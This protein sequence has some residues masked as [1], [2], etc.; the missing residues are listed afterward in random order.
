MTSRT[1][2]TRL[3]TF[4][5]PLAVLLGAI[6]CWFVFS[7][8][9]P[10]GPGLDP[11][12]VQYVSAAKSF[13]TH[14]TFQ[15]PDDSWDSPDSV[16]P[17]THFP[18]GLSTVLAAPV[19]LG[20]D[21]LQAARVVNGVAAL[22]TIGMVFLFVSWA[23]GRAAGT[24][25]AI[26]VAVTPAV[27]YVFLDVLSEPLFFAL[28][29]VTLACMVWRPRSPLW[30]GLGAAAAAMVRYAGVSVI[31]A[32]GVWSL[33]LPGTLRERVRRAMVALVPGAIALGAWMVRT[34]LETNGGGI[35]EFKV[36]G[37]IVPTL[38]EGVR[39]L[40]G[41]SAPLVGG[42]WRIAPA[43]VAACAVLVLA[44]D[45]M[46]RW[47]VRERLSG[48]WSRADR[49]GPPGPPGPRAA[50]AVAA[51]LVL[52]A[53]YVAVVVM[54]RLFAD[55]GIPLDERLLSPLM[56]LAIVAIVITLSNGWRVWR[57]TA[58][59]VA[60][61][62]LVCWAGASAWVTAQ[63][64]AYAVD[65]GNDYADESWFGSPLIAWVRDHAAGRELY[66]NYPTALYFHADRWARLMPK[67]P[68]PDT[69]RAFADVVAQTHGLIVAFNRSS[70]FAA[71]ATALMQLVPPPIHVV[72]RTH[73]GAIYELPR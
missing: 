44:R 52:A 73:D 35:R 8:T 26:A 5:V 23:E 21:P 49:S 13:A 11:D 9:Q 30:A 67:A 39:T 43:I 29:L 20:A 10:A 64:G 17:L 28:M 2:I 66:T 50:F 54:A 22:V 32:V 57:R 37:Q 7:W 18:P 60:A 59:I 72:V 46:R 31:A 3:P 40:V 55:P 14:G 65:T 15:V 19:A 27:S 24:V 71:S 51:T 63:E 34:R 68:T 58:R 48:T 69:A 62:L 45:A 70:R 41:W 36:Y 53:C 56:L 42:L 25:A 33:L 1:P 38:D 47:S 6:A 16:D 4:R 61:V 12:A